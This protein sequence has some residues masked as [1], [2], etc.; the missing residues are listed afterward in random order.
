MYTLNIYDFI[1]ELYIY[2]T[3]KKILMWKLNSKTFITTE[4][5]VSMNYPIIGSL[6]IYF[7]IICGSSKYLK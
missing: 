5:H 2:K 6:K 4:T 3:E 7:L 1:H